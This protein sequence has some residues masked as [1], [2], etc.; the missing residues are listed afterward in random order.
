[1]SF[2]RRGLT[3]LALEKGMGEGVEIVLFVMTLALLAHGSAR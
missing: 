3:G 2:A 1:M